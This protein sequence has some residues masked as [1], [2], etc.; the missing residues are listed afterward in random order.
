VRLDAPEVRVLAARMEQEVLA[1]RMTPDQ[2]A[3]R[4]LRAV[5]GAS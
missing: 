3:D 1:E 4:I 2:A 5:D